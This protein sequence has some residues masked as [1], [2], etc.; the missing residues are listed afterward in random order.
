MIIGLKQRFK[1]YCTGSCGWDM[2]S[3]DVEPRGL[4]ITSTPLL[5]G[6]LLLLLL[7]YMNCL[8]NTINQ[9]SLQVPA[10]PLAVEIPFVAP[11]LSAVGVADAASGDPTMASRPFVMEF[12]AGEDLVI[13]EVAAASGN[14]VAGFCYHVTNLFI[15]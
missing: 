12:E 5:I 6:L 7:L 9:K 3:P 13:G 11:H 14:S 4:F 2:L 15:N 8:T 10:R 1:K